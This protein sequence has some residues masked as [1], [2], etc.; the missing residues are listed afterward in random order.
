MNGES[1]TLAAPSEP[2]NA[3]QLIHATPRRRMVRAKQ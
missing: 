3:C 2:L 1:N